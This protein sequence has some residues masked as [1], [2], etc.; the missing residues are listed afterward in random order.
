MDND[1]QTLRMKFS[2]KITVEYYAYIAKI[3][4]LTTREIIARADILADYQFIISM[5]SDYDFDPPDELMEQLLKVDDVLEEIREKYLD[6]FDEY[7]KKHDFN[8][9][10]WQVSGLS[11]EDSWSYELNNEAEDD[12]EI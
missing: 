5:V 1:F 12:L 9:A 10:M 11:A 7:E 3:A 2:E 4:S 6:E 8:G